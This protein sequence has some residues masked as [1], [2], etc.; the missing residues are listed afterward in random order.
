MR[1]SDDAE[2][3]EITNLPAETSDNESI[4]WTELKTTRNVCWLERDEI[5]R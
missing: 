5:L 2:V 3:P 4:L 1:A